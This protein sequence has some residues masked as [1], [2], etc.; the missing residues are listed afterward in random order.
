MVLHGAAATKTELYFRDL[1]TGSQ[2]HPI[3]N[4][5]DAT[6]TGTIVADTLF[7]L[8][9]WEAP[10]RRIF[11]ADLR[12]PASIA[13]RSPS[14]ARSYSSPARCS[15]SPSGSRAPRP[16]AALHWPI[17]FNRAMS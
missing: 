4:G 17:A 6:F 16:W 14:S 7:V 11:V 12:Y 2:V 1:W 8:T 10:N 13:T 15:A 5:I 3:V 9:N